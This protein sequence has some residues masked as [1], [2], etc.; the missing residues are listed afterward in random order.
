MKCLIA[1]K[2]LLSMLSDFG[3]ISG[4]LFNNLDTLASRIDEISAIYNSGYTAMKQKFDEL[5]SFVNILSST[6]DQ[7]NNYISFTFNEADWPEGDFVVNQILNF[8]FESHGYNTAY[9]WEQNSF[10]TIIK[11]HLL[12]KVQDIEKKYGEIQE[13]AQINVIYQIFDSKGSLITSGVSLIGH[14]SVLN[15]NRNCGTYNISIDQMIVD[16]SGSYLISLHPETT[17]PKFRIVKNKI[18][19]VMLDVGIEG[20]L[21]YG[22]TIATSTIN[23][24]RLLDIFDSTDKATAIDFY[25]A[26]YG[27]T[28]DPSD[29]QLLEFFGKSYFGDEIGSGYTNSVINT[30]SAVHHLYLESEY[31]Q[32]IYNDKLGLS[33]LDSD[34]YIICA[35]NYFSTNYEVRILSGLL[36]ISRATANLEVQ[37]GNNI[38]RKYSETFKFTFHFP[39]LP[40]GVS[41]DLML[42]KL[43]NLT[44]DLTPIGLIS[45][46]SNIFIDLNQTTAPEL[47]DLH[48]KVSVDLSD[49]KLYLTNMYEGSEIVTK[50]YKFSFDISGYSVQITPKEIYL[51]ITDMSDKQNM[52]VEYGTFDNPLGHAG[53]NNNNYKI[54]YEGFASWDIETLNPSVDLQ[55]GEANAPKFNLYSVASTIPKVISISDMTWDALSFS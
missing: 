53:S 10:V 43:D 14:P 48:T 35:E 19:V 17:N 40:L 3:D 32:G 8:E 27:T 23:S 55:P 34:D 20:D 2:Q 47:T 24:Y 45:E 37:A 46:S 29:A 15:F 5:L 28:E 30:S 51:T 12:L 16:N 54:T 9:I 33:N 25:K 38:S 44:G 13:E 1:I 18:T 7:E 50:N 22:T 11:R 21:I 42:N 26:Y 49:Y 6:M 39:S 52:V 4:L 36:R 31:E 41:A